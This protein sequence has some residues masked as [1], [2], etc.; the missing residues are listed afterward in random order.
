MLVRLLPGIV[1]ATLA[2]LFAAGGSAEAQDKGVMQRVGG[3]H[4]IAQRGEARA[5][6]D[7]TL[8][9]CQFRAMGEQVK[10]QAYEGEIVGSGLW[11]VDPGPVRLT[12]HVIAPTKQLD[13]RALAGDYDIASSNNY[14]L[15]EGSSNILFGGAGDSIALE[16]LA[17]RVDGISASTRLTLRP[18]PGERS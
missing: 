15:A 17:P 13:E 11:L 14:K 16:L 1:L 5:G 10:A 8:L 2:M 7:K 3:L 6:A 18:S 12:W 9:Q 4:C